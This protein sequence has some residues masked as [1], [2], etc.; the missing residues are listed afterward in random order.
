[1]K[2]KHHAISSLTLGLILSYLFK[3]LNVFLATSLVGILLDLDHLFDF[4]HAKPK[5]PFNLK[6][7]FSTKTY[8]Q[9]EHTAYVPLHGYE[10][11]IL[12]WILTWQLDWSPILTGAA[13]GMSLHLILDD[14]GNELKT[15]SYFL[16]YR[17]YKKFRVFP[18]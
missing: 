6:A 10:F 8:M 12:L 7:F 5:N 3:N 11:A 14:I 13:A 18:E 1:M 16:T 4:W 9:K 17:I 15:L 2:A